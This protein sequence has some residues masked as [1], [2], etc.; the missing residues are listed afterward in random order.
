MRHLLATMAISDLTFRPPKAEP[1]IVLPRRRDSIPKDTVGSAG[2]PTTTVL[3]VPY[4]FYT[5][6]N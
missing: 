6:N 2:I 4:I 1:F 3:P 5:T